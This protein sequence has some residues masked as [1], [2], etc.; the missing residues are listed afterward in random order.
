MAC[1]VASCMLPM[2]CCPL[3][4]HVEPLLISPNATFVFPY[5]EYMTAAPPGHAGPASN[6]R[7][8]MAEAAAFI[9][10]HCHMYPSLLTPAAPPIHAEAAVQAAAVHGWHS[11]ILMTPNAIFDSP[12]HDCS[13]SDSCRSSCPSC[14]ST[15]LA[16]SHSYDTQCHI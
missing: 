4:T 5:H 7:Q 8:Y 9:M 6:L 1:T 13:T 10:S 16:Q 11:R 12:Y 15:C 3:C 2:P 14:G